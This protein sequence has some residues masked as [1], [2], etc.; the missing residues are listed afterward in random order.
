MLFQFKARLYVVDQQQQWKERGVGNLQLGLCK[1]N[2][3]LRLGMYEIL[4]KREKIAFGLKSH[5][6]CPTVMRSDGNL[7]V[8]LN[9]AL[10]DG[11]DYMLERE[12]FLRIVAI[13]DGQ[14]RH[15]AIKVGI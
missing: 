10:M 8:I 12:N 3:T 7:H 11:M 5:I 14:L 15:F 13:E 1:P 9:V 4:R 6:L 2:N